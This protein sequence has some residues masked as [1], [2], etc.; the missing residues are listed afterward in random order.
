MTE[1]PLGRVYV[2]TLRSGIVG[3]LSSAEERSAIGEVSARAVIAERASRIMSR[4]IEL[5]PPSGKEMDRPGAEP[6]EGP[7]PSENP[8]FVPAGTGRCQ[9]S[10]RPREGHSKVSG[11]TK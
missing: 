11:Y 3:P 6:G 7:G 5:I 2:S 9:G 1:R 8:P 10:A 4:T